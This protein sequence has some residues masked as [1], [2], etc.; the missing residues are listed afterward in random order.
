M[1]VLRHKGDKVTS[2]LKYDMSPQAM[3]HAV[4]SELKHCGEHGSKRMGEKGA[5]ERGIRAED[6]TREK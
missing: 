5:G 4:Y 3:L 6:E 1:S 2:R